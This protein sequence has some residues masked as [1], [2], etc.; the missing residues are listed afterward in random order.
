MLL[1][2]CCF[3]INANIGMLT[4]MLTGRCLH[5]VYHIR[6]LSYVSLLAQNINANGNVISVAAYLVI[7]QRVD[8]PIVVETFR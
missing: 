7:N 6:P 5:C 1:Y 8:D 4:I 2:L 3:E